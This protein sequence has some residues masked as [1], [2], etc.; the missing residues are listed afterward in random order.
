MT[1]EFDL[2]DARTAQADFSLELA[3]RN[4]GVKRGHSMTMSKDLKAILNSIAQ[5]G[6][7]EL[8]SRIIQAYDRCKEFR[9][10]AESIVAR[11]IPPTQHELDELGRL[12]KSS[13]AKETQINK[14]E[15]A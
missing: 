6:Y 7:A 12:M 2:C 10:M 13:E 15:S 9:I 11:R 14:Q 4:P 8:V 5:K 3:E 1:N